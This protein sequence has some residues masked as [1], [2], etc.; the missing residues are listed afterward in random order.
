MNTKT[1]KLFRYTAGAILALGA[2]NIF[3]G[4]R[5]ESIGDFAAVISYISGIVIAVSL[6][7]SN[8][9][10]LLVG[11][12][13]GAFSYVLYV[14]NV[15]SNESRFGII[16]YEASHAACYILLTMA[17]LSKQDYKKMVIMAFLVGVA[18][19]FVGIAMYIFTNDYYEFF[20]KIGYILNNVRSTII[21]FFPILLGIF[22]MD[23]EG[24]LTPAVQTI[25]ASKEGK[26][27]N[28]IEKLTKLKALLDSGAITQE[29]FDAKKKQL[30][31]L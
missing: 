25:S 12:G 13:I 29:E 14:I 15:L 8:S 24:A 16:I 18:G 6:F 26:A 22:A 4:I 17:L 9:Q 31:G 19:T 5:L 23:S 27:E 1:L 3:Y 10:C 20:E 2:G 21:L 7:T 30:L 11:C 28:P